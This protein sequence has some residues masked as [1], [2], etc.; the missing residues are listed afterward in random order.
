MQSRYVLQYFAI[1][2]SSLNF[3]LKTGCS[4]FQCRL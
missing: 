2:I 4:V 1:K 3:E